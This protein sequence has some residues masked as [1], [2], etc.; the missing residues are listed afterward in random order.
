MTRSRA[1]PPAGR[2]EE[3]RERFLKVE[4]VLFRVRWESDDPDERRRFIEG[5]NFGWE[6]VSRVL[7]PG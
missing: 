7:L 2:R 1:D 5:L 6:V 3:L 4:K